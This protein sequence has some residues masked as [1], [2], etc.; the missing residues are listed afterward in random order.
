MFSILGE[1]VL[2]VWPRS[3]DKAEVTCCCVSHASLN[4]VTGDDFGLVKLFHF[5]CRE[6][7]VSFTPLPFVRQLP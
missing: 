2:G 5:P 4:V 7:A 6:K 1:E 3:K